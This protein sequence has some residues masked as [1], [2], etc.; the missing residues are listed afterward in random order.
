MSKS[1]IVNHEGELQVLLRFSRGAESRI[2]IL[3]TLLLKPKN[4]NQIAKE[5]KLEWWSVQR[6]L[7]VL[8]KENLVRS[9][10]FGRIRF[11]KLTSKGEK[12]LM[13]ILSNSKRSKVPQS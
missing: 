5:S 12:A 9:V 1:E 10:E 11:Y 4:C 13:D 6:H 8:M 2:T 3:A 7:K